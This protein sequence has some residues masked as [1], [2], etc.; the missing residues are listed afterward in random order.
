M[1]DRSGLIRSFSLE[2]LQ[3]QQKH[4]AYSLGSRV[5]LLYSAAN[6]KSEFQ[7]LQLQLSPSSPSLLPFLLASF[8]RLLEPKAKLMQSN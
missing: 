6:I 4:N 2:H 8:R 5:C 7:N 3:Q 1:S